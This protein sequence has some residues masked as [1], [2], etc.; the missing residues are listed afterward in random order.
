MRYCKHL[1]GILT[2]ALLAALLAF[3][4]SATGQEPPRILFTDG[5]VELS[6]VETLAA[7]T[8]TLPDHTPANGGSMVGWC[9][10]V[11]GE[12][13]FLPVGA[14]Y[15]YGQDA[16]VVFEAV[17]LHMTTSATATPRFDETG[18]GL[19]FTTTANRAE[20]EHLKSLSPALVTG[21]LI[22]PN[23]NA[24]AAPGFTHAG[25]TEAGL[26]FLDVVAGDFYKTEAES[27]VFAGSVNQIRFEN[28]TLGYA[29]AGYVKVVYTDGSAGFV[30]AAQEKTSL[31][32]VTPWQIAYAVMQDTAPTRSEAYPNA[33]GEAFSP[34]TD[35][36]REQ[37]RPIFAGVVALEVSESV[38][39][40]KTLDREIEAFG[41]TVYAECVVREKDEA[42]SEI[43]SFID[44]S[45]Y[46][47]ALVITLPEGAALDTA[48]ISGVVL[49]LQGLP[50]LPVSFAVGNGCII[51]P[52]SN[53]SDNY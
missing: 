14:Q 4:V 35:A 48:A 44:V 24:K 16:S 46:E 31:P 7:G 15:A 34:Y 41:Q 52:F 42:W 18:L 53:Y 17:V 21:T 45:K 13:V 37:L 33:F 6:Q 1:F 43:R 39:G 8:L 25:M 5:A 11:A 49:S 29:A 32:S 9:A 40:G 38:P 26:K 10:T 23:K 36:Q 12:S 51:L 47:C 27:L 22:T 20:L 19:R 28:Y 30:Y 2:V 3:G 50:G